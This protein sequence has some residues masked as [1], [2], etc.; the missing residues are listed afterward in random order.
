MGI[1]KESPGNST[2]NNTQ[3]PSQIPLPKGFQLF[4]TIGPGLVLAM[5]FLGTGD[6]VSSSVSGVN[7]GY[8]LLWTLVISLIARIF[9]I[10]SL[11][12]YTLMNQYGDTQ[13]LEGFGRVAKWLPTVMTIVVIFSGIITQSTFLRATASGLYYLTGGNWAGQWGVFICA[14]LVCLFNIW[15]IYTGQQYKWLEVIA[16]AASVLMI[17]GFI[18]AVISL[19]GFDVAAFFKGIFTF[20]VPEDQTGGFAPIVVAVATIGTIAGN[21]PNLL[22]SGFMK[23]KGW[24]VAKNIERHNNLI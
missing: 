9:I 4:T 5:S 2:L 1:K 6:L 10:S 13:I 22:Y 15:M 12:K 19:G 24:V 7:Y 21:M 11:A 3:Y 18:I 14:V 8:I 20:Q 23:D 17:G 16:R